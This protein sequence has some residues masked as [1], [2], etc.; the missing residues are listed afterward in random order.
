MGA[1]AA[2][3]DPSPRDRRAASQVRRA[4]Q[5]RD[6]RRE[7]DDG[8]RRRRSS[9]SPRSPSSRRSARGRRRGGAAPRRPIHMPASALVSTGDTG[10]AVAA[11]QR[12][13]GV[14]DDG[15]FGPITR[16][17]VERFQQR[18]GL[19]VTGEV[20]AQTWAALFHVERVVRGRRRHA[21]MTVYALDGSAGAAAHG[22]PRR[23][24]SAPAATPRERHSPRRPPRSAPAAPRPAT[25]S[26]HRPPAAQS[27]R[28]AR[29]GPRL[30]GGGCGSGRIATPVSGTVTGSFGE[31]ARATST[32]ARTSRR[33]PGPPV[34]AAQC[35]TVT[36]A[37]TESGYGNIVCIQHAGGVS[38][39]YAHLSAIDRRRAPTST[40]AT[41]SAR[42][43]APAT[44][45]ARTC[46]S[47]CARTARP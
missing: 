38:T 9:R 30:A 22:R 27:R 40:S 6:A 2:A 44:A 11:I 15:I 1:F 20:D 47:R 42:S 31:A 45:P 4:P 33:R 26:T 13:V 3:S 7:R 5:G 16:G 29:P 39:C 36:Q 32:P 35:G 24:P 23:R 25:P 41:S 28:R 37:G 17:A 8:R 46:T 19:P 12:E 43:G 34:R 14:D 10:A 21:V 18:Y